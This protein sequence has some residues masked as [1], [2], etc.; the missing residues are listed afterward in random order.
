VEGA[1]VS[2]ELRVTAVSGLATCLVCSCLI[3]WRLA[4]Q[5]LEQVSQ[6]LCPICRGSCDVH[7]HTTVSIV[8]VIETCG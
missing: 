6:L 1:V 8:D 5:D 2:A 3:S 4:W 7:V